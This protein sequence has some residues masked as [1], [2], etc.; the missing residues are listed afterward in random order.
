NSSGPSAPFTLVLLIVVNEF[1]VVLLDSNSASNTVAENASVGTTV[2]LTVLGSDADV[3]ATVSNYS[4][5]NS[6]GGLFAINS[7][8]GV[9][10]VASALDYETATSH[11]IVVRG[12]STDG[13]EG[14]AE[15]TIAVTNVND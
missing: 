11:T 9:V 10:T 2:G 4:L 15:F 14:T 7:S 12:V 5:D 13:S 1:P 6:A 3:G 8:T